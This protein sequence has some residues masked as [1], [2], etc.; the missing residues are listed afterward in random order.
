M[1]KILIDSSDIEKIKNITDY[2]EISGLTTN[3]SILSKECENLNKRLGD[4]KNLISQNYEV[5]IQTTEK[6]SKLIFEEAIKLKNFFG[7]NFFIKIPIS[8]EGLKAAIKC[9]SHNINVTMTA[10]FTPMQVLACCN[11]GVDYVAPYINRIDNVSGNAVEI[12]AKMQDI[13][14]NYETKILAA[15]FKNQKQILE[16]ILLGINSVTVVPDLLEESIWHPYTDISI[17]KFDLD[18]KKKFNNKKVTDFL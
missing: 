7:D 5:H 11:I 8:K 2:Y 6:E 9:K 18:W 15:S 12:L 10:I 16:S 4:I 3:P 17:E 13:V 1:V 14:K